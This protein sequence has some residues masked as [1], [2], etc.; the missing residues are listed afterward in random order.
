VDVVGEIALDLSPGSDKVIARLFAPEER[1]AGEL[2]V[3]RFEISEPIGVSGDING[4]T[5]LQAIALALQCLSAA[6]YGSTEYRAGRLGIHGEFGGYLT[7]PAPH[8]VLDN[9]P[10]PF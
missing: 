8:V 2:W 1:L 7:I 10:F 3:C 9:A 5:S 4:S 6:L